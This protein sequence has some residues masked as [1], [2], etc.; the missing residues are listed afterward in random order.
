MKIIAATGNKS[1]IKEIKE[2]FSPLGFEVISQSEAEIDIEPEENGASF[3]EN[4][5][6]KARAAAEY[7]DACVIADDSG[8]CVDALDGRPGI[9]SARYAGE[10][11]SDKDK[12]AKL[13]SELSGEENRTAHFMT[14][15]AFIMPDGREITAHGRVDGHILEEALGEN[16][17]GYDPVFFSNELGKSFAEAT[18]EEKNSVSH[19][20][21]ALRALYEILQAEV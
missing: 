2:I 14:S 12:I 19:R 16:G 18:A 6:I 7:T 5:L 4:A 3:E 8:L 13:L 9:Y 17:F 15:V 10:G 21:R 1:K 11:A 20:G